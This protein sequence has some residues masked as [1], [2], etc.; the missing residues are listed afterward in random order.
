[1]NPFAM[2]DRRQSFVNSG[3]HRQAKVIEEPARIVVSFRASRSS[4]MMPFALRWHW[5]YHDHRR[6][7]FAAWVAEVRLPG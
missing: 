6:A 1:M 7:G 3:E 4:L 2:L 5:E